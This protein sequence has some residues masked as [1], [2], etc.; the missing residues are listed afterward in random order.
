M[1]SSLTLSLK[2][3]KSLNRLLPKFLP[4]LGTQPLPRCLTFFWCFIR[5]FCAGT[6][7]IHFFFK[8]LSIN[9]SEIRIFFKEPI[10]SFVSSGAKLVAAFKNRF[11]D[12]LCHGYLLIHGCGLFIGKRECFKKKTFQIF[13]LLIGQIHMAHLPF[14]LDDKFP[15]PDETVLEI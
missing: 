3:S 11:K 2:F 4:N 12:F 13:H 6:A 9:V 14:V 5:K 15:V 8:F 10:K 1:L 7:L